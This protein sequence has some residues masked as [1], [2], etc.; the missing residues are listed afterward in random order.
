M[1]IMFVCANNTCL[2]PMAE[3]IFNHLIKKES[4]KQIEAT[5]QG[6]NVKKKEQYNPL[7]VEAIDNMG[8][9]LTSRKAKKFSKRA[10]KLYNFIITMNDYDKQDIIKFNKHK[11]IYS[12]NDFLDCGDIKEPTSFNI[13]HYQIAA[14]ELYDELSV[15]VQ[16]LKNKLAEKYGS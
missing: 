12:L 6:I 7:A 9:K 8:I 13:E 1:L 3:A 15:F 4:I 14:E 5:S 10:L 11:N 2:S 16:A